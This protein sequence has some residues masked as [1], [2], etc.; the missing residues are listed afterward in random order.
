M[1]IRAVDESSGFID[2]ADR[3]FGIAIV[4]R[5]MSVEDKV[6]CLAGRQS[7]DGYGCAPVV[8]SKYSRI[9]LS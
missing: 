7:L 9:R 4:F 5:A 6:V 1:G 3:E 8:Q 2:A